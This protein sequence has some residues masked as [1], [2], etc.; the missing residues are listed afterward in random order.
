MKNILIIL[1]LNFT[2]LYSSEFIIDLQY[3]GEKPFIINNLSEYK[4]F[5]NKKIKYIYV[6]SKYINGEFELKNNYYEREQPI[7][8]IYPSIENEKIFLTFKN[9]LKIYPLSINKELKEMKKNLT[10]KY[11][12]KVNKKEENLILNNIRKKINL[13]LIKENYFISINI[14][15]QEIYLLK[16]INNNFK[17]LFKDKV[18]TG[19]GDFLIENKKYFNTP[20]GI[21]YRKK[22]VEHDWYG[23]G[24]NLKGYGDYGSKVFFLGKYIINK[25]ELN[26]AIHTTNSYREYFLGKKLSQG[27]IRISKKL[28]YYLKTRN[29][30]NGKKCN[31]ILIF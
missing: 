15:K 7:K 24:T 31:I 10:I 20:K 5:L 17:I 2:F 26:L 6:E 19:K 28:N 30:L 1:I 9:K 4:L 8:K 12:K 13:N 16:K 22:Y 27:C 18:S 11:F 14:K 25:K 21:F 23:L 3:N 29:L